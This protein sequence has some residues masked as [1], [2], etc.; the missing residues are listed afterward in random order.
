MNS[1]TVRSRESG[2][3]THASP[4]VLQVQKQKRTFDN[5][6]PKSNFCVFTFDDSA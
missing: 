6:N 4:E 3:L 5:G 2:D 1:L